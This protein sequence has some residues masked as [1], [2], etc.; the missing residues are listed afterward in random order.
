MIEPL[1]QWLNASQKGH[2]MTSCDLRLANK[3]YAD[4][5]TLVTNTIEDVVTLLDIVEP[6]SD[7]SGIHLNVGKCKMTVYMQK[8]RSFRKKAD[9]DDALRAQLAHITLGEQRIGVLT[10]DEPLPG[11]YLGTV[12]TYP[13]ARTST[14]DGQSAN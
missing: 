8:P 3:G 6:L 10:Q 11:G 13:Y 1:I 12:L 9:R 5:G 2:A 4:D 7:L 14:S